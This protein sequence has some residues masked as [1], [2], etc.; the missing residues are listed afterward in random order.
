MDRHVLHVAPR[1][2]LGSQKRS[3]D[4]HWHWHIVDILE[5]MILPLTES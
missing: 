1:A 4:S 2:H 3:R 5:L